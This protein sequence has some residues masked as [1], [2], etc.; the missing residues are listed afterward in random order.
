MPFAVWFETL[1]N[2]EPLPSVLAGGGD[3]NFFED[4]ASDNLLLA[5]NLIRLGNRNELLFI[6]VSSV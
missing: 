4:S 6:S 5:F 2:S 1:L 3:F